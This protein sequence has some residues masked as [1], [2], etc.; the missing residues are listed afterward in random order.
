MHVPKQS[1][2][3]PNAYMN[4]LR[5]TVLG[6]LQKQ[7]NGECAVAMYPLHTEKFQSASSWTNLHVFAISFS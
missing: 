2:N 7:K 1:K 4:V 3:Q 6:T 5:K